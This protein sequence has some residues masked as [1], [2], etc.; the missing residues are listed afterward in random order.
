MASC[1][2]MRSL[3]SLQF[4]VLGSSLA[5]LFGIFYVKTALASME[6][7]GFENDIEV[8]LLCEKKIRAKKPELLLVSTL[9]GKLTALDPSNNGQAL[10]SVATGKSFSRNFWKNLLSRKFCLFRTRVHVVIYHQSN[11][12]SQ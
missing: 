4:Y 12:I 6:D 10:W 5:L 2:N 8:P 1:Q 11:G 3:G 7:E 9:D